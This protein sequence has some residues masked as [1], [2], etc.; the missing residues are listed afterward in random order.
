MKEQDFRKLLDKYLEGSISDEEMQLLNRFSSELG[1]HI[2]KEAFEDDLDRIQVKNSLWKR[3]E[4]HTKERSNRFRFGQVASVAAVLIGF[5]AVG[6]FYFTSRGEY[7]NETPNNVITLK[8]DDGSVQIIEENGGITLTD[9]AGS[10]IGR[11]DGKE[12]IYSAASETE[13]LVYN[14]LTIPFGKT[15]RVSLSDGTVAHLNAGSSLKYPTRFL[16]NQ[17]RQVYITGEAYLQVAKDSL[18]PFIV[19]TEKLNVQVLGTEFNIS[20]YSEDETTDV[21]LV[22]GSVSLYAEDKTITNK[23]T[24]ILKPGFKGSFNKKNQEIS[25]SA[26]PTNQYTSW[27]KGELIFRNITFESI[28]KKLERHYNVSIVN[29]NENLSKKKFNANFGNEPIEKVLSELKENY[30]IDYTVKSPGTILIK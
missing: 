21:V 15:F 5:L 25:K 16:K 26:V 14:T 19:N 17:E 29:R 3:I 13:K 12:L 18:R 28:I 23:N 9:D 10:V 24:V 27:M 2:K 6:Y 7:Q 8:L 11:Q 4:P 22:E 30:G 1:S 20:S